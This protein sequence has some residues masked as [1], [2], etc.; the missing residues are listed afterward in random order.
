MLRFLRKIRRENIRDGKFSKF[1]LYAIGELFLVV[2]GI[3]IAVQINDMNN[4]RKSRDTEKKYLKKL[5]TDLNADISR[6]QFLDS[7]LSIELTNCDSAFAI[8]DS[9]PSLE[10]KLLLFDIGVLSFYSLNPHATTYQEMLNTGKL[11]AFSQEGVRNKII[12]Y[13]ND[14]NREE[15]YMDDTNERVKNYMDQAVMNDYW[16]LKR[17]LH[18]NLV[19]NKVDFPWLVRKSSSEMKA[20]EV[21][22]YIAQS[23]HSR[24]QRRVAWLT[25]RATGLK[26]VL[27]KA[28]LNYE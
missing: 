22:T 19:I 28:I 27:N 24:N 15:E 11:Y 2:V 6:Y 8:L 4:Q 20:V 25:K 7:M 13:Y 1:L 17:K 23:A 18:N 10:K 3:I 12:N 5:I 26:Q 16:L 21:L 9:Q 14:L